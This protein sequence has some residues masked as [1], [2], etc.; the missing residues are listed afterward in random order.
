MITSPLLPRTRLIPVCQFLEQF[1]LLS[2]MM[3][4]RRITF[5]KNVVA[6]QKLLAPSNLRATVTIGDLERFGEDEVRV[7]VNQI[8]E[9]GT[10]EDGLDE[11]LNLGH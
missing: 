7:K 10:L 9:S 2:Y 1:I 8:F 4:L 5:R 3:P 11:F 6:M